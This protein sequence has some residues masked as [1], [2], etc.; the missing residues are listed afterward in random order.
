MIE[1]VV[2]VKRRLGRLAIG[3]WRFNRTTRDRT[4]VGADNVAVNRCW[5]TTHID[6]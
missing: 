3:I 5:D 6:T 1:I 4:A 2:T